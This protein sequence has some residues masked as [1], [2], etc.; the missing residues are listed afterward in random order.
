M[1]DLCGDVRIILRKQWVKLWAGFVRVK[2]ESSDEVL[3]LRV[4]KGGVFFDKVNIR[5]GGGLRTV[6]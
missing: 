4:I 3:Y 1:R 5:F 6:E 2:I